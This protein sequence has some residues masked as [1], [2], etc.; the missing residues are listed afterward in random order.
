MR[1]ALRLTLRELGMTY[2]IQDGTLLITTTE[3]AE[4]KLTT[5]IY[6]VADLVEMYRDENG[7]VDTDFESLMDLIISTVQPTTWDDVGG[8][9]SIARQ[10]MGNAKVLAISQTQAV[11]EEIAALLTRLREVRNPGRR[12]RA[13]VPPGRPVEG[14]PGGAE[15]TGAP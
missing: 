13:E 4:S 7:N 8:P 12:G 2:L 15:D 9:G 1:S 3:A 11:H 6:Q 14:Q 5:R 10:S